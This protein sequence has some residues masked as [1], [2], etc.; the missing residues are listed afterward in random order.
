[1]P[2]LYGQVQRKLLVTDFGGKGMVFACY[3]QCI[4][5]GASGMS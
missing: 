5:S 1:M 3:C 2:V 4:S